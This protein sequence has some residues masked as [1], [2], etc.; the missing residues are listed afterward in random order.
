MKTVRD[1]GVLNHLLLAYIKTATSSILI[2]VFNYWY[3]L[4]T[5]ILKIT[6]QKL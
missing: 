2:D 5:G 1:T 4:S 6:G 3:F